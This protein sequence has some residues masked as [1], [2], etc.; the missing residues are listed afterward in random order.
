MIGDPYG[1]NML[2][3]SCSL[4][5]IDLRNLVVGTYIHYIQQLESTVRKEIMIPSI[6]LVVP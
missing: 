5:S 4:V 6:Q 1:P 2:R 3:I